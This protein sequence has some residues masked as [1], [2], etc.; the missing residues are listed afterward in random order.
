VGPL[1]EAGLATFL[2]VCCKQKKTFLYKSIMKTKNSGQ[3]VDDFFSKNWQ[4]PE[5]QKNQI[6]RAPTRKSNSQGTATRIHR[7]PPSEIAGASI[8]RMQWTFPAPP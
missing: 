5:S 7:A 8:F 6:H 4:K 1:F 3:N 2:K